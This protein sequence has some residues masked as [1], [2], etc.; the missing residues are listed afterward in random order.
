MY[1]TKPPLTFVDLFAGC[2][3]LSLGAM[4][5]GF[6]GVFAVEYQKNAFET[7][8]FNLVEKTPDEFSKLGISGYDWP[9][10]LPL[11]NHD[12]KEL[13]KNRKEFLKTLKGKIDLV[14]GGPPC[15]GFS[16]AGKR[17]ENDPRNQLYKSYISFINIVK[18][19]IL[20]IENVSGIASKF[21]KDGESYKDDIIEKLKSKYY[22]DGRL[23]SSEDFG[24]PQKRRRYFIL[25]FSKSFF[26]LENININDIFCE[27]LSDCEEFTKKYK[28]NESFVDLSKPTILDALSDL[29]GDN[30]K[31]LTY[32]DEN[33]LTKKY[34]TF[35]YK[36][37]SS[38]YQR[39]MRNGVENT[40][41][42]DSHRI[43]EHKASTVL[44][45]RKLI[46]IS[47]SN[48]NR[49]GF[50]FSKEELDIANWNSKK[51]VINVLRAE[52]PSPT[53]TTCPFDYIHY[54]N[55]RILTV[56]EYARIQSFPDWFQF[57]GIYATSGSLS[58]T[59]PR[60][61][62]IGNAVPPLMAE[63]IIKTLKKYL[64]N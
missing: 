4:K 56:R 18:P 26:K 33:A 62:Q 58:Y 40:S 47:N 32:S 22:V 50:K 16:H 7:L 46:E 48:P 41:N 35:P 43:G 60:Y 19:K 44:K 2:G 20:I 31:A 55:P 28:L 6:N 34:T 8:K 59:T 51:Q 11:A 64:I 38:D 61:S 25:G 12:I 57:K 21:S 24:V 54:S 45:Y 29:D 3:G 27:I 5:A 63:S 15:Q 42:I 1:S 9:K 14:I 17:R 39:V 13:I 37:I 53:I 10:D 30:L 49:V 52:K 23:I 36:S